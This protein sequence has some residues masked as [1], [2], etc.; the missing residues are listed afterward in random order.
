MAFFCKKNIKFNNKNF[1]TKPPSGGIPA[2]D[3]NNKIVVIDRNICLLKNLKLFIVFIFF[4]SNKNNKL[5]SKNNKN[6]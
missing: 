2:K 3:K 5:K 1:P 4:K 6:T